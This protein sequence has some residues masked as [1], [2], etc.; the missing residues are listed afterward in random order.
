MSEC[1]NVL[2]GSGYRGYNWAK[3]FARRK[4]FDRIVLADV[5]PPSQPLADG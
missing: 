1:L 3:R 2:G 4:R 5:R